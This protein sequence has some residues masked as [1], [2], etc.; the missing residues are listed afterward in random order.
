MDDLRALD[1][2][3]TLGEAV[4]RWERE[5]VVAVPEERD[6]SAA[7]DTRPGRDMVFLCKYLQCCE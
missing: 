2:M 1:G 5:R 6:N 4:E 3:N 7:V